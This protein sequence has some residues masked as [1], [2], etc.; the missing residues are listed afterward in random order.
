M[1]GMEIKVEK[2]GRAML[3]EVAQQQLES[4]IACLDELGCHQAAAHADMAL[5]LLRGDASAADLPIGSDDVGG[6]PSSKP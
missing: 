5:N 1:A 6:Q 4:A 3:V 2:G